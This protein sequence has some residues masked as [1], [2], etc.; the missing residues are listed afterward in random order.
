MSAVQLDTVFAGRRVPPWLRRFEAEP[1]AALEDL[2]LGG[3]DLGH[4][5]ADEP[6]EVLLDWLDGLGEEFV[7]EIDAAL[8]R[9]I[10]LA[11]G[12][13]DLAAAGGSAALL[14][15]AWCRA[16]DLIAAQPRLAQAAGQLRALFLADRPFLSA[17]AEGRAR[18]PEGR[19]WLALARHQEDRSLLAEWWRLCNLPPDVPWYH[20]FYGIHGLRG[21]PRRSRER[22]GTFPEEVAEGL[23]RLAAALAHQVE[24][25]WLRPATARDEFLHLARLTMGAYPWPERWLAFWRHALQEDRVKAQEALAWV[26]ALFPQDLKETP[27]RQSPRKRSRWPVS[28]PSW[29]RRAQELAARIGHR[30]WG[31]LAPA[32]ALLEEQARF[33]ES[34]GDPYF[35]VRSA[36]NFAGKAREARPDLAL[37]WAELARRYDPWNAFAWT[38]TAAALLTLKRLPESLRLALEAVQRFPENVVARTG[39]AEVLKAQGRYPEAEKVYRET[40]ARFLHDEV[41]RNGLAEVLK[42]QGRNTE[43][44][45]VYRETI[46]RF[47]EDVVART[48]L[49]EVLKA[50]GR[51]TEAEAVYRETIARFPENVVARNG[52]AEVLKAQGR[53]T[54]AEAVYRE[55]VAR[56]PE[57]GVARDGL[58]RLVKMCRATSP[59]GSEDEGAPAVGEAAGTANPPTEVSPPRSA[60]AWEG[61]TGDTPAFPEAARPAEVAETRSPYETTEERRLRRADVEVLLQDLYLLRRWGRALG[62]SRA[63]SSLRAEARAL[64]QT[65]LPERDPELAGAMGLFALEDGDLE[66]ALDL[67]RGATRRFPGSARVR[68][69]LARAEREAAARRG[70]LDPVKPEASVV[71]WRRLGRLDERFRPLQFLGEGRTWLVQ[72]DGTFVAEHARDSLG[73]LGHWLQERLRTSSPDGEGGR[74]S[75]SSRFIAWWAGEVQGH[76]FGAEPVARH[77]DIADLA[78]I[79]ERIAGNA[80]L[81][82]RLEEDYVGRWARS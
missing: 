20:G 79:Q 60:G 75:D 72:R 42:A 26:R 65:L 80:L 82:D 7:A 54:E 14:A 73:S 6:T 12:D 37:E 57:D 13:A 62:S 64:L 59:E 67:L 18:D 34:T 8:A 38:T 19:A 43:A 15:L 24:E 41:A 28:D 69:A 33:A 58:A 21:L 63:T 16:A 55:T 3:A 48:G 52:L 11:W 27:G 4:L 70:R 49:A 56:F 61:P 29:A 10:D 51:N 2:L 23:A 31:A 1:D 47:P 71:P 78:P 40:A 66:R 45:A 76:V 30:D 53:N 35:V 32:R 46:A 22:E 36:C 50:Q 9:W 5:S 74:P 44:E 25:G 68:Y 77:E 39:L 81:L 17:L